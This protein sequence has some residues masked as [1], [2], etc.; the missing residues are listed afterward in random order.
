[1]DNQKIT[2]TVAKE[3]DGTVQINFYIPW[4]TIKA[5]EDAV[6]EKEKE[7]VTI[8]GFRKGRA[9]IEKVRQAIPKEQLIEK[10]LQNILPKALSE[11]ITEY[12]ITPALYPKFELVS[13]NENETWQIR[14]TTCELPQVE[15]GDYKKII[16]DEA[17]ANAIWTPG[18]TKEEPKE[19]SQEEKE[20]LVLKTLIKSINIVIP[21]ILVEEEVNTKLSRLLERIEKLG[22]SLDAYLAS[23][24]KNPQSLR[25]EYR[26]QA[27]DSLKIEL[28]LNRIAVDEKIEIKDQEIDEALKALNPN[29]KTT[30]IKGEQ[31][32][33]IASVLKRREALLALTK[34]I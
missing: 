1:M 20:D 15:L 24:G 27:V 23:I 7:N 33:L 13:A 32:Q 17:K 6:I 25:E 30:E 10:S 8:E 28:I 18:K 22:L 3:E 5:E 26:N 29:Q 34:L 11:A 2:S 12:K 4:P 21:K 19:L 31:R 9:P 16:A 14:V